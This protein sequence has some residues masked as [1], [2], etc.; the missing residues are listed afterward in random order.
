M[1][2]RIVSVE[3][4]AAPEQHSLVG[5]TFGSKLKAGEYVASG[6]PLLRGENLAGLGRFNDVASVFVTA[7]K[8]DE[9]RSQNARAGDLIFTQ[10]GSVGQVGLIALSTSVPPVTF[11]V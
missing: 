10:Q 11:H 6:V 3:F 7:A 5:N 8:A 2:E 4:L 9:L 1:T